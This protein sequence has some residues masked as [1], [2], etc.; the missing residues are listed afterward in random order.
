MVI[1]KIL[2]N[3]NIR[4]PCPGIVVF[5]YSCTPLKRHFVRI[6]QCYGFQKIMFVCFCK[7]VF[8]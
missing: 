1:Q 6:M 7:V 4:L 5:G 2:F 3:K 8:H